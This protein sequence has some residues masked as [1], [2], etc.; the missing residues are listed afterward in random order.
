MALIYEK[1]EVVLNF[2]EDKPKMFVIATAKQQQVTFDQLLDEV[3]NSCGIGRAVVKASVEGML[4]RTMLF[5]QYG[6]SVKMGDL[7]SF[8]PTL[9]AKAQENAEDLGAANV[10]R[11]KII[12]T[13]GKRLKVMLNNLSINTFDVDDEAASNGNS[14][15]GSDNGGG[16]NNGGGDEFIDPSA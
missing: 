3:S 11:R 15:G 8:K 5:M 2:K 9:N 14:S 10:R 1:R 16:G 7:G 13:P 12:F 6:M 4:D